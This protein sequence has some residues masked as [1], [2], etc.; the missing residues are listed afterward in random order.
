M[1][2]DSH[3][4]VIGP[5]ERYPQSPSRTYLAAVA[6]LDELRR[7][8]ATRGVTRFVIVQ[9]SFYGRD[10][11]VLLEALDA[12]GGEGRGVAVIAPPTSIE[13]V[14]SFARR[15]VRG[16]RLNLYSSAS[17]DHARPMHETFA[18]LAAVAHQ[19]RWHIE[20]IAPLSA[21]AE[22]ADLLAGSAVPVVIDHYGV[23]GNATPD[24]AD[25]P[26]AAGVAAAAAC[27]DEAVRAVP[28]IRRSARDQPGP[29]LA[30]CDSC[31]CRR[32]LRLGQRLAAHAPAR[33]A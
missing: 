4:H 31:H 16:L 15:G 26:P 29:A 28:G 18:G 8:G 7:R 23:Y 24:S 14:E 10:N 30:R 3:V 11:T 13:A 27:L 22:Q 2:C 20:V 33:G 12:L 6:T 25:A 21:L 9:P 1:R 19:M 5:A 17:R 32:A